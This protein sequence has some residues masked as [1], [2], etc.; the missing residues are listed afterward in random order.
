[1]ITV[2]L[3]VGGIFGILVGMLIAYASDLYLNLPSASRRRK[4]TCPCC[5]LIHTIYERTEGYIHG[6]ML[7]CDG[8]LYH[9]SAGVGKEIHIR[10][11]EKLRLVR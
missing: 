10:G 1:M 6:L 4:V 11:R 9:I 5:G 3:F 7:T 8:C 2:D